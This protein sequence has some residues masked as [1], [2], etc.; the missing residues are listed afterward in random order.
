MKTSEIRESFLRFFESKEHTI[1]SSSPLVPNNDPTLLFV[2]AGMNQF[3]QVFLGSDTRP[4]VRATTVQK[5]VRAGGKHNDLENVGYTARHLTFFEMLG[6]F[7]FGNYFKEKAIEYSWEF[8][9]SSD[10][11]GIPKEKL[12]VTVYAEDDEAYDIWYEKIGLPKEKII[13]IGDNKGAKY[14]SDNFWQMG[15]T[16][17]CG[18][19]TEIFYDHGIEVFGGPP[20]SQDED[21]DRFVE[22]WNCVFMQY[23]RDDKGQMNSLPRPSVDTGMGLERIAAVM[24]QV[25]SNFEIDLFQHLIRAVAREVGISFEKNNSS[26]NV[27]ADHIRTCSFLIADGVYPGNE[28]RSYVLRRIIRRAIRHGYK[29]RQKNPFLYRLVPDLIIEMGEA[30]PELIKKQ[31]VIQKTL[32][33]E[34]KKFSQT[35]AQGMGYLQEFLNA[36]LKVLPGKIAFKLYD[37]YGFPLDLTIEI[38]REKNIIVEQD[39]FTQEMKLQKERA[40]QASRFKSE[41]QLEYAGPTTQF[42][43]YDRH[44][45]DAKILALYNQDGEPVS[46]LG[47]QDQGTVVLDKTPF[48]A[49]SGG[50]IGDI[51]Y[52]YIDKKPVFQVNNTQKIKSEV[53]GHMGSVI[54]D[55]IHIGQ[56]IT[57]MIDAPTRLDI[58]RNHSATHLLHA[59]LRRVIGKHVE[60]R[61]SLVTSQKLRFDFTHSNGLTEQELISIESLVNQEIMQDSEVSKQIMSY[62]E[63]INKGAMALFSEKYG[64]EV[65]VVQ[66]G[67]FS[68]E[69]CGGTHVA[70]TGQIGF[71]KIITEGGIASGV[72]RIEAITGKASILWMQSQERLIAAILQ[73][74]KAQTVDDLLPKLENILRNSKKL[75]LSLIQMRAEILKKVSND[76]IEKVQKV[77]DFTLIVEELPFEPNM[78]REA[79]PELTGRFDNLVV[80]VYSIIEDKVSV[81]VG[82]SKPISD[83]VKAGDLV[84]Y[85]LKPING[86]GGGRSDLAQGVALYNIKLPEVLTSINKVLQDK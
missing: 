14:A 38:C 66:M 13:K 70:R 21:G 33:D 60:Q 75:E 54:D 82:V 51:G 59:A 76:L 47:R 68:A 74:L 56:F 67:D 77:G 46:Q 22:I 61:G 43:G 57:T 42:I 86:K 5:C 58:M 80:V 53:F 72:R 2:N 73:E 69:L 85:I 31:D 30:Y 9:T 55:S 3:K 28:G 19:C 40:R 84:K 6:N 17:P 34:E 11:L 63:A 39:E 48:Y 23:N 50:Q 62:D 12:L 52:F 1:V 18:P 24:Q 83:R 49:E 37:T 26:L 44:E 15:D 71:F 36:N 64:D 25:H 79:I 7:S 41:R 4:Y 27:I 45:D 78:L 10:W 29:L 35:L 81:C 20:G 32:L 16:G 8:L 65:C